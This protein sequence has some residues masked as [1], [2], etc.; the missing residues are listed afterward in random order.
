MSALANI[1]WEAFYEI[2]TNE[3]DQSAQSNQ[4]RMGIVLNTPLGL[5]FQQQLRA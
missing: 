5:C 3:I 1:D 4:I 2:R